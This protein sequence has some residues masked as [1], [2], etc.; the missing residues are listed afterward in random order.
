MIFSFCISCF[1][2]MTDLEFCDA[3][4]GLEFTAVSP[5]SPKCWYA[6]P[7]PPR[8][9]SYRHASSPGHPGAGV[10]GM[11]H[12]T[13]WCSPFL[14]MFLYG[15]KTCNFSSCFYNVISFPETLP[16]FLTSLRNYP[17]EWQHLQA[18]FRKK[19]WISSLLLLTFPLHIGC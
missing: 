6:S 9:W 2:V 13:S 10:A 19:Q 4:G 3:W 5:Q 15:L 18:L 1:V 7:W 11:H 8:C 16:L 12:C 14:S 17:L